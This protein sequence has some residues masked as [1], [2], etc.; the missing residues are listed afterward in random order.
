MVLNINVDRYAGDCK[1]SDDSSPLAL[2]S[3][4]KLTISSEKRLKNVSGPHNT[5]VR[6]QLLA[7]SRVVECLTFAF[8][9]DGE[10]HEHE[11]TS[12]KIVGQKFHV[13][14]IWNYVFFSLTEH[15]AKD[16]YGLGSQFTM[17]RNNK[18]KMC[19]EIVSTFL[20]RK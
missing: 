19:Q 12:N 4:V 16:T 8:N 6:Y 11:S 17:E 13:I 5:C 3:V 15:Q 10:K 9:Q 20:L 18:N 7:T 1:N 2:I 14:F